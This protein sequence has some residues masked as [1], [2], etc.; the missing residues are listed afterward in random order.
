VDVVTV[1]VAVVPELAEAPA[2]PTAAPPVASAPPT[3]AAVRSLALVILLLDLLGLW[4]RLEDQPA[5]RE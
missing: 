5:A 3:I 4:L 1:V 2:I